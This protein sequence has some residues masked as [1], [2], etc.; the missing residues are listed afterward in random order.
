MWASA[1]RVEFADDHKVGLNA[2]LLRQTEDEARVSEG[3]EDSQ[4]LRRFQFQWIEDE[5][6]SYYRV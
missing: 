5:L 4:Q 2:M 1:A 6:L 3:V